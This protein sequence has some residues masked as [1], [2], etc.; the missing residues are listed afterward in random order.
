MHFTVTM[1]NIEKSH[2]ILVEDEHHNF[3]V[4]NKGNTNREIVTKL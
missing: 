3:D 2:P 4:K 1:G